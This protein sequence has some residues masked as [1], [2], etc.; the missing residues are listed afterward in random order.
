MTTKPAATPTP[1]AHVRRG[2]AAYGYRADGSLDPVEGRAIRCALTCLDVGFTLDATV[3]KLTYAGHRPRGHR[4]HR[5]TI[6]RLWRRYRYAARC[7]G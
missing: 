4:W 7:L 5:T 6:A 2:K 3:R 1:M